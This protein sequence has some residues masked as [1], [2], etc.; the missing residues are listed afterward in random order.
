MKI[1]IDQLKP[2]MVVKTRYGPRTIEKICAV[3]ATILG[4]VYIWCAS[5]SH[6]KHLPYIAARGDLTIEVLNG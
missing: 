5:K 3:N 1:R 2:G 4:D 6:P